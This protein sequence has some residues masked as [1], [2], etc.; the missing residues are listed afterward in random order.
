MNDGLCQ[1]KILKINFGICCLVD[2]GFQA[3]S[4]GVIAVK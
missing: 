1:V 4:D 2:Q 3:F